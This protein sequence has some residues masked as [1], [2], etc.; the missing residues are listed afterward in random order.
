MFSELWWEM[1][2]RLGD[3]VYHH[4][5]NF[6]SSPI[7]NFICNDL[8]IETNYFLAAGDKLFIVLQREG[9]STLSILMI[10]KDYKQYIM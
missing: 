10:Q 1:N 9:R 3:I 8:Q 2:V 6:F 5:L 7:A 4:C